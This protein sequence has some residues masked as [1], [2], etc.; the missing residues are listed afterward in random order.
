MPEQTI[1]KGVFLFYGMKIANN[2]VAT[3]CCSNIYCIYVLVK[4]IS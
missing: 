3:H 1:E 2:N 4:V